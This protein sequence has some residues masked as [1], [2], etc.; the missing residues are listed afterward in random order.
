MPE[1]ARE[2]LLV[3][4]MVAATV[5]MHMLGL[6]GLTQLTRV[7]L[8]HFR[9]PWLRLDRVLAPL[10]MVM[11]LFLLHALEVTAYA[12][13]YHGLSDDLPNWE[14]ALYVSAGAYSTAGWT[15]VTVPVGWRVL[16]AFESLNGILLLGWST[17]FL[18]QTLHR[19]LQTEET[20]PLPEGALAEEVVEEVV[21]ELQD[22][23]A[24][25]GIDSPR[26]SGSGNAAP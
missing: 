7:Q 24:D 22:A 9:T 25:A 15:G 2:I 16:A 23:A 5:V 18:F 11:G 10:G 3:V 1:L 4:G 21:E 14:T 12:A 20:H 8:E 19:I 17:A 6:N 26:P 13:L